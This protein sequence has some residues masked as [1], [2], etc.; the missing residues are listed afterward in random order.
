[1]NFEIWLVEVLIGFKKLMKFFLN[2]SH[3]SKFDLIAQ[4]I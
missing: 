3:V 4:Q 2:K 1:L